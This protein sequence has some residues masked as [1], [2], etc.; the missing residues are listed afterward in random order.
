M[1]I[2]N[3]RTACDPKYLSSMKYRAQFLAVTIYLVLVHEFQHA[4]IFNQHVCM[5]TGHALL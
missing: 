2:Q 1:T 3:V 5:H 4:S